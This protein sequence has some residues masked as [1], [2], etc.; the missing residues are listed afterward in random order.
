MD[1]KGVRPW[2]SL[3]RKSFAKFTSSDA[4]RLAIFG[5]DILT[6]KFLFTL[7]GRLLFGE[8]FAGRPSAT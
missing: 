7:T 3:W 1:V 2:T 8:Q 4:E 5:R 6:S